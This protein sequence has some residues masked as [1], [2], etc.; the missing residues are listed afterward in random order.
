LK[1]IL[2]FLLSILGAAMICQ[3][4]GDAWEEKLRQTLYKLSN[5][6]ITVY[7]KTVV[8]EKGVPYVK[9]KEVKGIHPGDVYNPTIVSNYAIDYYELI[10]AG[11]DSSARQKFDNCIK[12]LAENMTYKD[13]FAIFEFRWRQPFY[14]SVG[15]PWTSGMTSGRAI[16][17]FTLAY[18]LNRAQKYIDC[19]KALLRG[20][21]QPI[22]SGGFTYK[23][24]GGWWYEEF[25]DSNMHTPRVL[26][27]HIFAT[28][29]VYKFDQL[30]ENDSANFIF[31]QGIK[32]LKSS[33]AL[34]DKGDGW[35]Y[36]DRLHLVSDKKYHTLLAGQMKQL[37]E[38]TEDPFFEN[39]Y[40]KWEKPLNRPYVFRIIKERNRSGL[41]LMGLLTVVI[42]IVQFTVNRMLTKAKK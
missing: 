6:S 11:K 27:G 34:Y 5:D 3:F 37:W 30:T 13:S 18:K 33:L 14:D 4:T 36:Y 35:S 25:A 1:N 42:F 15:A 10:A 7:T 17:A 26:D 39:Y 28:T 22:Q 41:L 2:L 16:E 8:D 32:A 20:F 31:K 23:E 19:A 38:M 9:Y 40:R 21:Y 24:A 12:W 29:G